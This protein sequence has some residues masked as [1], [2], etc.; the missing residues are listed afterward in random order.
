MLGFR[1]FICY[2]DRLIATKS[3]IKLFIIYKAAHN[4]ICL[5]AAVG[6]KTVTSRSLVRLSA[7]VANHKYTLCIFINSIDIMLDYLRNYFICISDISVIMKVNCCSTYVS[8]ALLAVLS[9]IF[10]G[11]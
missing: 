10:L 1:Y 9:L 8:L 7:D 11:K 5:V 4:V 3:R 6:H 2:I